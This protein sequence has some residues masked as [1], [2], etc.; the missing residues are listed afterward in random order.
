[1][2]RHLDS[3]P[4]T[5][6]LPHEG[7]I[8]PV[9]ARTL[10]NDYAQVSRALHLSLLLLSSTTFA[11]SLSGLPVQKYHQ[12]TNELSHKYV[13]FALLLESPIR[14][15]NIVKNSRFSG[16]MQH[17]GILRDEGILPEQ[18]KE[19]AGKLNLTIRRPFSAP[20]NL[21]MYSVVVLGIVCMFYRRPG[22]REV[23]VVSASLAYWL[24]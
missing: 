22:V 18:S 20:F 10:S 17:D 13:K 12:P 5:I 4:T 3:F 11:L 14:A 16:I 2:T 15:K 24:I 1:M 23:E 7:V 6:E 21:F 9:E 8:D 19:K